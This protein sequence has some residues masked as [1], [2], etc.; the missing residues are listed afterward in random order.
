MPFGNAQSLEDDYVYAIVA[1]VLYSKPMKAAGAAGLIWTEREQ[2]TLLKK[3][4][5][6]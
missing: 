4:V 2:T 6:T 1:Y 5:N 3:T